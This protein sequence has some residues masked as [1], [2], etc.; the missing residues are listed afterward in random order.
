[1]AAV[2]NLFMWSL[3][4]ILTM[5]RIGMIVPIAALFYV[6]GAWAA[7]AALGIYIL[8]AIT[9]Y[10]DGYFARRLNQKSAFGRF[11]DPIADKLLV[12]AVIVMLAGFDRIQGFWLIPAV[13]ILSREVLV[14]GLREFLG[15][16]R[17]VVHVTPLAK[18]KTTAQ[19]IALGMLIAV[20]A[21]Q[22]FIPYAQL[23]G[24]SLLTFAA[25]LTAYTGWQYMQAGF[26]HI[27]KAE[28]T[29]DQP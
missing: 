8:S 16:L 1:M 15:P 2:C 5:G 12:S 7:W 11:L 22:D 13:V 28:S 19:L 24:H 21:V 9:D 6:P 29:D 20:P 14:A 23:I 4:N 3:P 17:V 10:F 18:W 26:V 25:I 27:E